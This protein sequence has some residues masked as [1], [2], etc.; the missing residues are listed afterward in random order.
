[1][2]LNY[3][4]Y[5]YRSYFSRN[6][7]YPCRYY[8]AINQCYPYRSYFSRNC[9]WDKISKG[10]YTQQYSRIT[11]HSPPTEVN[12]ANISY[13]WAHWSA[14]EIL[15]KELKED[16]EDANVQYMEKILHVPINVSQDSCVRIQCSHRICVWKQT[17]LVLQ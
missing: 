4:Y 11:W 13:F 9:S 15:G 14:L 6:Q 10:V 1:M 8:F 5:P 3:Q 16:V 12:L 7:Y 2:F 17:K